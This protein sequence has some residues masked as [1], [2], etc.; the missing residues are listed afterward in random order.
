MIRRN[1]HPRRGF[2]LV[3]LIVVMAIISI[4]A[5]M[6]V[7]RFGNSINYRR[8]EMA[9]HR[10][11]ADLKLARQRARIT[12]SPVTVK[13]EANKDEYAL[14][15]VADPDRPNQAYRVSLAAEPHRV[16]LTSVTIG[17]DEYLI[18][19]AY[20]ECDSAATILIEA[21][22]VEYTITLT[23]GGILPQVSRT[24]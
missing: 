20:G 1:V 14:I 8:V 10:I 24:R 23:R 17:G 12:A 2:T 3:E 18:F 22:A 19:D 7:P 15:G 21:G 5:S 13:F 9:A 4:L 6:A 11:V 16:D